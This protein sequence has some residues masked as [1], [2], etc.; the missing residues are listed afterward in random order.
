MWGGEGQWVIK[1]IK[2]NTKVFY[3]YVIKH[4]TVSPIGPLIDENGILQYDTKSVADVL[5]K[6]YSPVFSNLTDIN[7]MD[8]NE[9]DSQH[10][11]VDTT[12]TVSDIIASLNKVKYYSAVG[13]DKSPT[14][15]LK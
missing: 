7:V 8:V 12:F 14:S 11:I 4:W 5:Q 9:V 1:K 6:Q 2:Q 13:L 15:L 3:V 10:R